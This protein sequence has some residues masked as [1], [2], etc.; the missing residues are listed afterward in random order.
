[1]QRKAA[2]AGTGSINAVLR[3][4]QKGGARTMTTTATMTM[5]TVRRRQDSWDSNYASS[6]KT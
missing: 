3:A 2:P 4:Q 6:L 1:M 5:T